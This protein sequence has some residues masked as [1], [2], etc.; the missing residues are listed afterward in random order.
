MAAVLGCTL[1]TVERVLK[2]NNLTSIDI[3]NINTATQI[4]ISG[5]KSD[6][7]KA[8][9]CFQSENT[10]YYPL[11]VSAPFHS[12]YMESAAEEFGEYLESYTFVNPSIRVISNVEA[13]PYGPGMIKDYLSRQISSSVQWVDTIRY[14]MGKRVNDY[15]ELGPGEV[16]TKMTAQIRKE[17][18][19]FSAIHLGSADFKRDYGLKYACLSGG[20]YK[21]IAS[22]EL[23]VSMGNAGFMGFYGSAGAELS[24]VDECLKYIRN[25]L[26]D[27]KPY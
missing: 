11:N 21:G 18:K 17:E 7:E 10:T 25:A 12:R 8:K 20:M 19:P 9:D 6:I 27:D 4:V 1:S 23:V 5:L 3:A 22:K 16:L 14:L 13:R 24:Q 26:D 15:L 2:S